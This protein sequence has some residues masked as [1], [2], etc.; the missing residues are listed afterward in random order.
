MG[1]EEIIWEPYLD[2]ID[3][4]PE[5]CRVGRDLWLARVPLIYFSIAECHYPDRVLR[6]FGLKP[7][8]PMACV[9]DDKAHFV[10]KQGRTNTKWDDHNRVYVDAWNNRYHYVASYE[11]FR[12]QI[13]PN[14]PY[15]KWY[16]KIT[17][18]SACPPTTKRLMLET[19]AQTYQYAIHE[20]NEYLKDM[21]GRTLTAI[22]FDLRSL[23][24]LPS[25]PG[26]TQNQ[27]EPQHGRGHGGRRKSWGEQRRGGGREGRVRDSEQDNQAPEPNPDFYIPIIQ[28][29]PSFSM[30]H[31]PSYERQF[32]NVSDI[33]SP[34]ASLFGS[35]AHARPFFNQPFPS[36]AMAYDPSDVGPSCDEPESSFGRGFQQ[37]GDVEVVQGEDNESANM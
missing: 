23:D 6:Q 31:D 28:P 10:T 13:S 30:A 7:I 35:G 26:R 19:L 24:N 33:P 4:L 15:L 3:T 8:I 18:L 27:S 11:P 5:Y 29:E 34:Y 1:E 9:R 21:I 22:K 20:E 37:Y 17:R 14:D 32:Q 16:K 2:V 36:L 12:G 25:I